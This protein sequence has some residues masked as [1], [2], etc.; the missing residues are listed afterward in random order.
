MKRIAALSLQLSLLFLLG[1]IAG[2][3]RTTPIDGEEPGPGLCS[4]AALKAESRGEATPLRREIT[5]QGVVT[6]NDRYGEFARQIVLE[7]ASGGIVVGLEAAELY[8]RYPV[9]MRLTLFCNGLTL[10]DYG[11]RPEL[12]ADPAGPYGPTGIRA[13][14]FARHLHPAAGTGTAPLPALRRID[15]LDAAAI[16]TFVRLEGVRFLDAGASWCDRDPETGRTLATEHTIVDRAGR[17]LTV[18]APSS[19][20]YAD[21]MIPAGEGA[22]CGIVGC[23]AGRYSL[24]VAD[25][26]IDFGR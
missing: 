1:G 14:D 20:R 8:R 12:V 7:D 23:F 11:G 6:A 10:Y 24:R 19:L 13:D 26:G 18:R 9:G 3:D 22:L 25:H 2:C 21:E 16:D 17:T 15:E 5:V 4:I